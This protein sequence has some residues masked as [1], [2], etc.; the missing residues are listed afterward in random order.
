MSTR[1]KISNVRGGTAI[2][3]CNL[4]TAAVEDALCSY[5][6]QHIPGIISPDDERA[7]VPVIRFHNQSDL[8]GFLQPWGNGRE[9]CGTIYSSVPYEH[10]PY[11]GIKDFILLFDDTIR[12][13]IKWTSEKYEYRYIP[14]A[15]SSIHVEISMVCLD[16][17][18]FLDALH[19]EP[20]TEIPSYMDITGRRVHEGD[21]ICIS[22]HE[23]TRLYLDKVKRI[24]QYSIITEDG[25]HIKHE[26]GY[27]NKLVVI[28]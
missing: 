16:R 17:Q 26:P 22:R 14:K 2:K 28:C 11:R 23:G 8:I 25:R 19:M 12:I 13:D 24:T 3:I 18:K 7:I 1:L 4:L 15:V 27:E 10:L 9:T 5:Y 6:V 20:D 21:V